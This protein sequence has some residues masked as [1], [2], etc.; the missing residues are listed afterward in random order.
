MK[1]GKLA[2]LLGILLFVIA[3]CGGGGGGSSSGGNGGGGD[4][5]PSIA[6]YTVTNTIGDTITM[7]ITKI[8]FT[9]QAV[10]V[11][12]QWTA[13]NHSGYPK[14][15]KVTDQEKMSGV[16][17]AR[18]CVYL[19]DNRGK[20]YSHFN[21]DGAAYAHETVLSTTPVTGTYYFPKLD[22]G[23]TSIYFCDDDWDKQLGPI[24]VSGN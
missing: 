9:T 24:S 22:S 17:S 2:I 15:V 23:V 19:K 5:T 1:Q 6:S 3:G 16:N 20:T 12:C 14:I 7:K 4:N 18:T 13:V 10:K 11:Y 21:G 8:E